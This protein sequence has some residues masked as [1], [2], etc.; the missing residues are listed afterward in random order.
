MEE[1][2]G[3]AE[4]Q[5]L[6]SSKD[7]APPC[8]ESIAAGR[9]LVK[10]FLEMA[11][12]L[13]FAA[14]V[15]FIFLFPAPLVTELYY[16]WRA[17]TSDTIFGGNGS[18]FLIFSGPVLAITILAIARRIVMCSRE[19]QFAKYPRFRL[20]TFPVV[21]DGPFGVVSAAE[22]IG[23]CLVVAY[24]V[25]AISAY[26]LEDLSEYSKSPLPPIL[27]SATMLEFLASRIG[28]VGEFC[29]A[30]LFLPVARGSALLRLVDIPFERAARY[31]VW[32]GHL[33]MLLF[34]LHGLL[35]VIA[36]AMQGTLLEEITSWQASDTSNF[37]GV[38]GLSVGLLMWV[39]SLPPVRKMQFEVFFYTHQLYIVFVIFF[40]MHVGDYFFTFACGAI[41]LFLLDRFLRFCQ[42]RRTVNVISATRLP[43]GIIKLVLSKPASLRYN[44]LSSIFL[45]IRELSWLQWHPFSVASSPLDGK[46]HLSVLIKVSGEWT[47]KLDRNML[48]NKETCDQN[49]T[50]FLPP[51]ITA[52]VEGPYGH[53]FPYHLSYENLVL[54]AGGIGISPFFAILSDILHRVGEG[55]PCLTSNVLLVWAIK[56]SNELPLL[57]TLDM[58]SI[59]AFSPDKLNLDIVIYITQE[60]AP[61]LEEGIIIESAESSHVFPVSNGCGISVLAGTGNNIWLGLYVMSSIAGFIVLMTLLEIF[62]LLSYTETKSRYRGLLFVVCMLA[63]VIIFGGPAVFLWSCWEKR[64]SAVEKSEHCEQNVQTA[65]LM[66]SNLPQRESISSRRV[67]YCSRP[68]FQEIFGSVSDQWGHVDIGVI[69]CGPATLET[70]VAGECRSRNL[71]RGSDSPI[72][73]FHSHSFV[74]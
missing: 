69:V 12:G 19:E 60:S 26:T 41:F 6:L 33:T 17:L 10:W 71:K 40:A 30:F 28:I 52:S 21:V 63:S 22:L 67:L 42:S 73:H 74:L 9:I 35:Y 3:S 61:S 24:V 25:W 54:V 53:E 72:F 55:K 20:S 62:N 11:M 39:T 66:P 48:D 8:S 50:T 37:A 16:E 49:E 5:Y 56:K 18:A 36:W 59:C 4:H 70:S 32:L 31:H 34:T 58:E 43:C 51:K 2:S 45:Q 47:A 68:N 15:T 57:S 64:T 38:I 29:L 7:P 44:A 46:N 27:K 13:I 14:W 23:I 65:P 1:L